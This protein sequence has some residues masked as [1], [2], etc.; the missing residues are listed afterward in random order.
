MRMKRPEEPM[1]EDHQ[2]PAGGPHPEAGG[3]EDTEAGFWGKIV[4]TLFPFLLVI[5]F[6]VLE[7]WV[8]SRP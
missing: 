7:W 8:R 2:R 4:L 1:R 5:L 6:L 3:P